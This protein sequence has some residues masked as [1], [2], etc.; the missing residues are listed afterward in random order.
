LKSNA[1]R[2]AGVELFTLKTKQ[3]YFTKYA[4]G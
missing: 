3:N 1:H 2:S 4:N